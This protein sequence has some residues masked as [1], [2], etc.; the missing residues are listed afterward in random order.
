MALKAE[1]NGKQWNHRVEEGLAG[2]WME[3]CPLLALCQP[4]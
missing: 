1:E 2:D 4:Y 3:V